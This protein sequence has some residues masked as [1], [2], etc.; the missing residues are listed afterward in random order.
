MNYS[1]EYLIRWKPKWRLWAKN[2]LSG[3]KVERQYETGLR[4]AGRGF[5]EEELEEYKKRTTQLVK[6]QKWLEEFTSTQT[7]A[8]VSVAGAAATG[9]APLAGPLPPLVLAF[10]HGF[11]F[12]TTAYTSGI[13][14]PYFK[15]WLDARAKAKEE[16]AGGQRD[17]EAAESRG[18]LERLRIGEEGLATAKRYI[19][20][21]PLYARSPYSCPI[22]W[23]ILLPT[24]LG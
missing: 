9:I 18:I 16:A 13:F 6:D 23:L 4:V 10:G 3:S 17:V 24:A 19:S 12:T 7:N 21:G 2:A 22:Q 8:I 5:D 1:Q 20:F 15:E 14:N 11:K